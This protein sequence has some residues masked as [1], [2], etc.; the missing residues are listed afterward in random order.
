MRKYERGRG[1]TWHDGLLMDLLADEFERGRD[2]ILHRGGDG[3]LSK[4]LIRPHL[5]PNRRE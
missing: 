1:G 2:L 3:E 4:T 5:P